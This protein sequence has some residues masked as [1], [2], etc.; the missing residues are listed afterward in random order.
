MKRVIDIPEEVIEA[1]DKANIADVDCYVNDY[2]LCIGKA[3]KNSTPLNEVDSEDCKSTEDIKLLL[4]KD[5]EQG[6]LTDRVYNRLWDEIDNL[7]SVYPKSDMSYT[8]WKESYEVEKQRN[9]QLKKELE[10]L[11][12]DRE[13]EK[14]SGK[15]IESGIGGAKV[16]SVCNAHMGL[17]SFKFCPNCG[18]DMREV[19]E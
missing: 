15:W 12:L 11:K 3:I 8:L 1:F 10:M 6:F 13:C 2:D 7:P 16:C 19:E 5:Y 14:P 18:A 9:T 4:R 17:S